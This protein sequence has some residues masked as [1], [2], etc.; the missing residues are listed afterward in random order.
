MNLSRRTTSKLP[1]SVKQ[2]LNLYALAA[3]AAGVSL[4]ALAEPTEA[5]IV[6]TPAHV[7]I[8][9]NQHYDLDLNHGGI[10]DFTI[11]DPSKISHFHHCNP[12]IMDHLSALPNQGNGI[13]SMALAL[14]K[15]T[16]IGPTRSFQNGPALMVQHYYGS[17]FNY[18]RGCFHFDTSRGNWIRATDRYL[19]LKFGIRSKNHFGWARLSVRIVDGEGILA[20]LTGYAY[21]TIPG[22]AI[23]AGQTKEAEEDPTKEDFNPGASLKLSIP[24]TPQPASLGVLA[25]GARGVPLWRRKEIMEVV[26]E[27]MEH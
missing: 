2:H 5:K 21:E 13:Q 12:F 4:L 14:S 17:E 1:D 9:T 25:L 11:T 18:L 27:G 24:D 3:R 6:Y 26:G 23:K 22:K 10:T 19:G 16:T 15:G 20:I 7:V 8:G